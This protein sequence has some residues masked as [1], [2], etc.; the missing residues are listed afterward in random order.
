MEVKPGS[1]GKP[2]PGIEAGIV[3]RKT[4]T[5]RPCKPGEIG[6]L[7]LRSRLAVDDAGLPA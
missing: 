5:S 1:M 4:A 2:L 6:E 7:A 3:N